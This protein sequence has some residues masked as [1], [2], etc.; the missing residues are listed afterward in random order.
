M[1][2]VCKG[3]AAVLALLHIVRL[4]AEVR[5][6]TKGAQ[7]VVDG[8]VVAEAR[9]SE[10]RSLS[11][12]L[13]ALAERFELRRLESLEALLEMMPPE[14]RARLLA[15]RWLQHGKPKEVDA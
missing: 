14:R 6:T 12:S 3:A 11:E 8:Q 5:V 9:A 15:E 10:F 13:L 4:G 2:H 1:R 7:V